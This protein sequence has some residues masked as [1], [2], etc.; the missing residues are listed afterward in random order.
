[1]YLLDKNDKE[2]LQFYVDLGRL[3]FLGKELRN[4]SIYQYPF[5]I[6]EFMTGYFTTEQR[7]W[8][9]IY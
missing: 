4:V 5:I 3:S 7:T 2:L 8:N 9:R 6:F 1:M